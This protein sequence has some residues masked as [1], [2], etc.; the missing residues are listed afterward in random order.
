[1]LWS[2]KYF[3]VIFLVYNHFPPYLALALSVVS[4][5]LFAPHKMA[6]IRL[7]A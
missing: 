5:E 4:M 3:K 2:N 6:E 1:M 7:S